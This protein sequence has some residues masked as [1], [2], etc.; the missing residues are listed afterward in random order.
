MYLL[1]G[2]HHSNPTRFSHARPFFQQMMMMIGG[3]SGE[4]HSTV[5]ATGAISGVGLA[6]GRHRQET[7]VWKTLVLVLA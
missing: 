6:D 4:F 1:A 7:G 2:T 5:G 3:M